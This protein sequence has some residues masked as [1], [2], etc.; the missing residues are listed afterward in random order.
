MHSRMG[1]RPWVART[2]HAYAALL[3]RRGGPGD[4]ERAAVLLTRALDTTQALGMQRL[5]EQVRALLDGG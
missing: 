1:A 5:G 4:Q 2:Q 3:L